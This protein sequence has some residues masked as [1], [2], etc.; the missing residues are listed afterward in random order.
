MVPVAS[1]LDVL[2]MHIRAKQAMGFKKLNPRAFSDA[3]KLAQPT[4]PTKCWS[5]RQSEDAS[6]EEREE[7]KMV[8]DWA[9]EFLCGD[10]TSFWN[11]SLQSW[12][13]WQS[14][15]KEACPKLL[16]AKKHLKYFQTVRNTIL[17]SDETCISCNAHT[18]MWFV[19]LLLSLCPSTAVM[20]RTI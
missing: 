20:V 3:R 10:G 15:D 4:L 2:S 12:A 14:G 11:L 6:G 16:G 5:L 17:W 9:S 18:N 13:L 1:T 8:T 19:F 7:T